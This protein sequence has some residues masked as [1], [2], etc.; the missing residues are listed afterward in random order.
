[1]T[2]P[3]VAKPPTMPLGLPATA[4]VKTIDPALGFVKL[5]PV[6]APRVPMP[7]NVSVVDALLETAD[8]LAMPAVGVSTPSVSVVAL[9]RKPRNSRLPP[10]V[11]V[12]VSAEKTTAPVDPTTSETAAVARSLSVPF[13]IVVAP[14]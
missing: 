11:C 8:T 5:R 13:C 4:A 2:P 7:A 6:L 14:M 3:T 1:M 9:L 10:A 12:T